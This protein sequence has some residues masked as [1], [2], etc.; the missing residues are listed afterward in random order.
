MKLSKAVALVWLFEN[1]L[2]VSVNAV[3]VNTLYDRA[4]RL[5]ED[6]PLIDTHID[7]PQILAGLSR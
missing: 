1:G 7:L 4:I 6:T 3:E 2:A 5:M